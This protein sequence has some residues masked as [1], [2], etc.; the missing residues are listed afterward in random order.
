LRLTSFFRLHSRFVSSLCLVLDP[1]ANRLPRTRQYGDL[2]GSKQPIAKQVHLLNSYINGLPIDSQK[3]RDEICLDASLTSLGFLI[4]RPFVQRAFPGESKNYAEEIIHAIIDAFKTRL[5]GRTWLDA[6]TRAKALEKVEAIRVK[7]RLPLFSPPSS[8]LT[9][10]TLTDRLSHLPQYDRPDRH[11]ALLRP[12]PPHR[13]G[14]LLRER[15]EEPSRGGEE[16][17]D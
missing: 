11:R 5:P 16:E 1:K 3:P 2:L 17:V 4:G 12:E 15:N 6:A 7:V 8:K 9:F 10:L 14:G 13:E